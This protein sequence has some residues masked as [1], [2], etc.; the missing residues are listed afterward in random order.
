LEKIKLPSLLVLI[1]IV[2]IIGFL[3]K[4]SGYNT[5]LIFLGYRFHICLVVP[6]LFF[7]YK[8][9]FPFY[10]RSL[11]KNPLEK[12]GLIFV[13][14]I[15]PLIITGIIYALMSKKI[16][17]SPQYFYEFGISSIFDYPLYL[18]WNLPQLLLFGLFITLLS[19]SKFSNL[20]IVFILVSLFVFELFFI[21]N[22]EVLG[23][24]FLSLLAVSF[25][26]VG[27]FKLNQNIYSVSILSFSIL[28]SSILLFGSSSKLLINNFFAAQY[29][30]W[31]GFLCNQNNLKIFV[32]PFNLLLTTLIFILFS[33][34]IKNKQLQRV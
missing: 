24:V 30:S 17:F 26:I 23:L 33:F 19:E 2:N 9:K 27:I 12:L 4:Y 8:V 16:D 25:L 5:F 6:F 34:H 29:D 10:K 11:K 21:K 20:A 22:I 3:I 18:F 31:Q 14:I 13:V 32:I 1:F 28:W 7:L 15:I